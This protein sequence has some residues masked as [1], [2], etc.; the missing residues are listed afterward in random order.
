MCGLVALH[1]AEKAG[2]TTSEKDDF[3]HM[4]ILN[5]LRGSHSTGIAGVDSRKEDSQV[6]IV[7]SIGSPYS[8]YAYADTDKFM[9]RVVA[10]FDNVIGHGRYATK[11]KINATNAHPYEEGNIVLAHNGVINNYYSLRDQKRHDYIDVD[12]HLIAKLFDEEGAINVLPSIEGAYVFIWYDKTTRKLNIA[13]NSQR[14]LFVG[15]LKNRDTLMFASE[16]ETLL[17]NE[18][19]NRTPLKS[20]KELTTFQIHSYAAGETEPE[21][22]EYKQKPPKVYSG[23]YSNSY[24]RRYNNLIDAWEEEDIPFTP[25][26]SNY[27]DKRKS[28]PMPTSD[29]DNQ[30]LNNLIKSSSLSQGTKVRYVIDDYDIKSGYAHVWGSSPDYPN[31]TFRTSLNT[32]TENELI[33]ADYIEGEVSSIYTTPNDLNSQYGCYLVKGKIVNEFIDGE[34]MVEVKNISGD[35]VNISRFRLAELA[36]KKCAWCEGHLLTS[37]L[38]S[39][40]KLLIHDDSDPKIV[41]SD[42]ASGLVEQYN[43]MH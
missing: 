18:S 35:P 23:G 32:F 39:P 31:I 37:E 6:S 10:N 14:P 3:K 38:L 5:S 19:R 12:S 28:Q 34:A 20:I 1:S 33:N 11:G 42:C 21:I 16:M 17:W 30:L 41:C 13:R 8:L 27:K 2:F 9:T 29:Y 25:A 26:K 22:T 24:N 43:V 4:L 36:E 40:D 7:K 15:H